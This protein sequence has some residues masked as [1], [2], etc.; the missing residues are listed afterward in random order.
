M[1]RLNADPATLVFPVVAIISHASLATSFTNVVLAEPGSAA[2]FVVK[3]CALS[4]HPPLKWIFPK[5]N[6]NGLNRL[7]STRA[8]AE[9]LL[10]AQDP[11]RHREYLPQLEPQH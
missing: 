6:F 7:M 10:S 4:D 8:I 2:C 11:L 1:V 3:G 5:L 9:Y